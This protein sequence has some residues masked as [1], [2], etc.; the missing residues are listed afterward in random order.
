MTI[1]FREPFWKETVAGSYFMLDAFGGCCVYDQ[2][3]ASHG[4]RL[5][6]LGWL[7][8]GDAAVRM[9]NL[10]DDELVRQALESL[11][12]SLRH[13]RELAIEGRVN[14]WV[15]AVNALPGGRPLREPDSRHTPDPKNHPMLFVVGDYLFDSTINGV[16]DS[17]EC[18]AE[19][20]SEEVAEEPAA[21]IQPAAAA[22]V[23]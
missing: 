7:I 8:S 3:V 22:V 6:V 15:G 4:S 23:K 12:E 20:I 16:Y 17:A 9:S 18:V 14:R 5:G 1:L 21:A 10:D 13:G 19:W 11:P 2:T